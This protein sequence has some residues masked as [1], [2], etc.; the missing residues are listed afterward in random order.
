MHNIIITNYAYNRMFITS[1]NNNL[2]IRSASIVCDAQCLHVHCVHVYA[3]V[4]MCV[5]YDMCREVNYDKGEV[6]S[7]D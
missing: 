5:H 1:I 2:L 3:C 7:S 6:V 4:C